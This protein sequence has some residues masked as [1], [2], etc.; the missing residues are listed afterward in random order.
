MNEQKVFSPKKRFSKSRPLCANAEK[1]VK[2]METSAI[3]PLLPVFVILL[4]VILF[5]YIFWKFVLE[6]NPLVRDFFDLD[7]NKK[8]QKDK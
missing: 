7:T 1:V 8:V 6:P 2:I 5:W 3:K 4:I